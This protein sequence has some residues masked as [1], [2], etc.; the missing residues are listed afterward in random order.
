[1][2]LTGVFGEGGSSA[3]CR[4]SNPM[5]IV[6][7]VMSFD[8]ACCYEYACCYACFCVMFLC[9][10]RW[11]PEACCF[12]AVHACIRACI[13]KVYY[14]DTWLDFEV[15]GQGHSSTTTG[16]ICTLGG[17]FSLPLSLSL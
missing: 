7:V 1:M 4:L 17:V 5:N 13:L 8:Y 12:P 6:H 15:K 10:C 3:L 14:H 2:C 11:V 9:L 16:Q